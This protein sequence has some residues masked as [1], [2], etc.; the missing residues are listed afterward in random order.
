MGAY[1]VSDKSTYKVA[2][3]A[4]INL[5]DQVSV[6]ATGYAVAAPAP[7]VGV[8][9]IVLGSS[10]E[11]VNNT[12]GADGDKTVTVEHSVGE[13]GFLYPPGA[14]TIADIGKTVYVGANAQTVTTTATNAVKSG[15]LQG[16]E[17]DGR[18]RVVFTL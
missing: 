11:I 12:G 15:T 10:I 8:T 18:A 13:K 5:R 4:V 2:A 9:G 7:A 14:L 3:N 16:F 17:E 6:N 1:I